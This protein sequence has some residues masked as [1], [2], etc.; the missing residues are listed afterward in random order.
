MPGLESSPL[1]TDR[2]T[3]ESRKFCSTPVGGKVAVRICADASDPIPVS[4]TAAAAGLAVQKDSSTIG[5]PGIQQTLI[6][7]TV[8]VSKTHEFKRLIVSC[9]RAGKFE[10]EVNGSNIGNIRLGAGLYDFAFEWA[11]RTALAGDLVEVLYT[12]RSGIGASDV[13]AHLMLTEM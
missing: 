1:T 4:I 11:G 2:L 9:Q 8:P 12:Q 6:S 3:N 13:D 7:Y 10:V 5:T